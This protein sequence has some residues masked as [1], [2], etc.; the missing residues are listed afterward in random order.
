MTTLEIMEKINGYI[1]GYD[2]KR[3]WK[4]RF[5]L[6]D[7]NLFK[8]FRYLYAFQCKRMEAKNCSSMGTRLNGGSKF[9]GKPFLPHGLKGIFVNSNSIIGVNATI[10]QG[11]TIGQTDYDKFPVIG[12]N[13]YIGANAIIIGAVTIG[14]N[15]KIGA[16]TV[17]TK[18]V[19]SNCTVIGNPM[20]IIKN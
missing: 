2:D 5:A 8:P 11:V 19:P 9:L 13:V 14:N 17:V 12:D 7:T 18:D 10:W 4:M 1:S 6:Y 3:Y 15:V 16:G 20:K